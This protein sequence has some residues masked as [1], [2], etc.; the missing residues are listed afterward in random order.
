MEFFWSDILLA[1]ILAVNE[2]HMLTDLEFKRL[3]SIY[4]LAVITI[5]NFKFLVP[6]KYQKKSSLE[7]YSA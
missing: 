4:S 5:L 3:M 1:A 7:L 2:I 6:S